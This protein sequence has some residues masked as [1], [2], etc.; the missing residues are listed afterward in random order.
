MQGVEEAGLS[1][2]V[3]VLIDPLKQA[4]GTHTCLSK[5]CVCV[6]DMMYVCVNHI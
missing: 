3:I 4:A 1:E 5:G 6:C 2:G